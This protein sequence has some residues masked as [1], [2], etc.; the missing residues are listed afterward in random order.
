[1]RIRYLVICVL[2]L[3]SVVLML[4]ACGGVSDP[5]V[6]S[7][8]LPVASSEA[9]VAPA[10][11]LLLN[12]G[13][14]TSYDSGLKV[15]VLSAGKGPKDYEDHATV[16]IEVTYVNDG[17]DTASYSEGD[18]KL[19]DADGARTNDSAYFLKDRPSLGSGDL[20]PGGKKTGTIYFPGGKFVAVVY[21]SD[22]LAGESDLTSWS[23]K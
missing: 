8:S 1:M 21:E 3:V 17:T 5:P 9:T 16:K 10:K 23:I 6:K 11:P 14:T 22:F 20:A 12:I 7:G 13:D 19:Q 15:T 4:T 2:C 18:W